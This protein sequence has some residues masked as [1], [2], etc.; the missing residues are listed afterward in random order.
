[1]RSIGFVFTL[2]L[3][4]SGNAA[5]QT[6]TFAERT[7]RI[8]ATGHVDKEPDQA[9]LLVAIENTATSAEAAATENAAR[10]QEMLRALEGA[11]IK[12]DAVRTTSYNVTPQYGRPD[13]DRREA[14]RP[15][16]GYRVQNMIEITIDDL[17]EIGHI[18]DVA[19]ATHADRVAGLRFGLKDRKPARQE[20]LATA[21]K[22]AQAEAEVLA[23]AAGRRRGPLLT[24]QTG[25][26]P[27]VPRPVAYQEAR[28]MADA[29]TPVEPGWITV[30]AT[31]TA[32][33]RLW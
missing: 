9:R 11:G 31:I 25:T 6:P 20:A 17:P 7:I 28:V 32:I 16:T 1:M 18:I 15:I 22:S 3:L 14:V 26:D 10:M 4:A 27:G 33:Y 30:S 13:L 2:L 12:E 29:P 21:L 24:I 5:T 8:T 19:L 23:R